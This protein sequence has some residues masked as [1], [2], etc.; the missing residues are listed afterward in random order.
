MKN[1]FNIPVYVNIKEITGNYID[2]YDYEYF[3]I[4]KDTHKRR[5]ITDISI[6]ISYGIY[7]RRTNNENS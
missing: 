4:T 2:H 6:L 3:N 1:K 5:I 7:L